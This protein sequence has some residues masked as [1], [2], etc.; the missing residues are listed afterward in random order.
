MFLQTSRFSDNH[1]NE[2]PMKNEVYMY[3]HVFESLYYK[4]VV[5]NIT[6]ADRIVFPSRVSF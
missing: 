5:K 2:V 4:G 1:N 6:F 3:I